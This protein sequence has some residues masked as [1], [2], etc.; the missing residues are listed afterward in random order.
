M[1]MMM[2]TSLYQ[3]NTFVKR[4]FKGG[5]GVSGRCYYDENK[6]NFDDVDVHSQQDVCIASSLKQQSFGRHDAPPGH[7]ILIVSQSVFVLTL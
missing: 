6:L 4:E 3:T 5:L 1:M 7:I 2:M